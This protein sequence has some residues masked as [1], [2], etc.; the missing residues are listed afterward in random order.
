M[1]KSENN[2]VYRVD[3]PVKIDVLSIIKQLR[4]REGNKRMEQ[5]TVE[6]AEKALAVAR[7]K[8]VYRISRAKVINRSTVDIDGVRFNS[9]ALSK[10]L[11]DQPTVYPLIATAGQELDEL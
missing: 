5:M 8:A 2:Q 9:R 6:M 1:K 7:P 11:E 4:L 3:I 10:C